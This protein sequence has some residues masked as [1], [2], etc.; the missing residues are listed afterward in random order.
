MLSA[1]SA[2]EGSSAQQ[3]SRQRSHRA[4]P[5]AARPL[6][7]T[8]LVL[9]LAACSDVLD[10]ESTAVTTAELLILPL[11]TTAPATS[12]VSFQ[13]VTSTSVVRTLR[14]ADPL[15]TLFAELSFPAGSLASLDGQSI[16]PGDSLLI[17]VSATGGQYGI[18]IKPI[19]LTFTA[20]NAPSVT[21]S[22]A[23][24]G[25]FSIAEAS[26]RYTSA[27][28]YL[29]AVEVWEETTPGLWTVVPSTVDRVRT[30]VTGALSRAG[31]YVIAA[32]R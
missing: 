30:A 22:A 24:Y 25:D 3:P 14:H 26:S 16:A 29:A 21:F 13:V 6:A 31:T 11:Q 9:V 17:T 19:A 28:D 18:T 10:F 1:E 27:D 20:G 15:G 23:V 4:T 32:R 5:L 12:E 2:L 7:V 8:T